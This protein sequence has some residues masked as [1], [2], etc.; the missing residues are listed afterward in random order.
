[1]GND[2]FS[3][4]DI[5]C[6]RLGPGLWAEPLNAVTNLSF[7]IAGIWG[8]LAIRRAGAGAFAMLLAW[9][10]TAIGLGSAAFHTYAN[11]LT[12]LADVIPIGLFTLTYTVFVLRVLMGLSWTITIAG[13]LGFYAVAIGLSS[14]VPEWLAQASN[15]ST[16][17]LVPFL[18]L[19]CFGLLLFVARKP[20]AGY[21]LAATAV[22]VASVTFRSMDQAVCAA[23]PIG[24]HFMW[25]VLNGLLLGLLLAAAARHG[26][27]RA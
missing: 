9:M 11:R 4:I 6:E 3:A 5:Y 22:F 8:L 26:R 7:L 23:F 10:V 21:V 25:H 16:G 14:L 15:G 13:F 18:S 19:L 17:Y 2:L 20:G 24:T 27:A 1:M 12:M